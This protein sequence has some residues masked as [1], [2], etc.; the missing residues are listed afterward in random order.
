MD[1]RLFLRFEKTPRGSGK[2]VHWIRRAGQRV[3]YARRARLL[4]PCGVRIDYR[5][6]CVLP[7]A[8]VVLGFAIPGFDVDN[9]AGGLS[10]PLWHI[11][12]RHGEACP[13]I[14]V[15]A[16]ILDCSTMPLFRARRQALLEGVAETAGT[17]ATG[18][19]AAANHK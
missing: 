1:F 17:L 6:P 7:H 9:T 15:G 18:D 11:R 14:P 10:Q 13:G 16:L 12:H 4:Q 2:P 3:A 19:G 8:R 5:L